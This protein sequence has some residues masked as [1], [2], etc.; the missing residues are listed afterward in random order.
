MT[1]PEDR[2]MKFGTIKNRIC[3]TLHGHIAYDSGNEPKLHT[4]AS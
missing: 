2:G 3:Q 1:R 4:I